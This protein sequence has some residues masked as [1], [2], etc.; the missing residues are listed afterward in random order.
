MFR[1][2][3][4]LRVDHVENSSRTIKSTLDPRYV[5]K[6]SLVL[7]MAV[8]WLRGS[9]RGKQ[10]DETKSVVHRKISEAFQDF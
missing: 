8:A 3:Y 1:L 10:E 6:C 9:D 7:I 2:R 4:M 5:E